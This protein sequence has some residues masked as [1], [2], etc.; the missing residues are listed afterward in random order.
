VE[1]EIG[2]DGPACAP[3]S[4]AAAATPPAGAPSIDF[5]EICVVNSG[6]IFL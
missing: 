6:N 4:G 2:A 5:L 1:V 3:P